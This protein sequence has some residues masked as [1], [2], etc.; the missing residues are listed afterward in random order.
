MACGAPVVCSNTSSLP[1]VAGEAGVYC[2]PN[3][4]NSIID[5]VKK[6]LMNKK[7]AQEKSQQSLRQAAKFS[8]EKAA[9][10][11]LQVYEEVFES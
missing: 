9:K 10:A 6:I 11:T 5:G 7:F 3:S 2:D 1:E 8:W 4:E